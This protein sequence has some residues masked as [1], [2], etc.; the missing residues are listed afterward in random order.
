M[1]V[2]PERAF[3]DLMGRAENHMR[4]EKYEESHGQN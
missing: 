3:R 1:N 2:L 4:P